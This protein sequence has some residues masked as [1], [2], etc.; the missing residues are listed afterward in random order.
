MRRAEDFD[1]L[2]I[3]GFEGEGSAS[4]FA[5]L[6]F[7]HGKNLYVRDAHTL[8]RRAH[9]PQGNA[10]RNRRSRIE[11]NCQA[12]GRSSQCCEAEM[13]ATAHP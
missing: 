8:R 7:V 11:D 1:G 9:G 5:A 3:D 10:S 12:I 6:S 13:A 2:T 4:G